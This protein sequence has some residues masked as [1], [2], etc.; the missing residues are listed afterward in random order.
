LTN[1]RDG[2]AAHAA[3]F[4]DHGQGTRF[5]VAGLVA[6]AKALDE[7]DNAETGPETRA[8]AF[9]TY[10]RLSQLLGDDPSVLSENK[11]AQVALS[12]FAQYAYE[13]GHRDES[14]EALDKLLA[15]FPK[16]RAYLQRAGRAR[17]ELRQFEAALSHWRTVLAGSRVGSDEWYEA[18]Y[19]Q[20]ACLIEVDRQA[21]AVVF[22]QL[23]VL[24]PDLGKANWREKFAA[25]RDRL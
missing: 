14:A 7:A 10:S 12:K 18:K 8:R 4:V 24:D 15:A 22:R 23:Q 9:Q 11:N 3:W 13:M 25:L 16:D 6:A 2:Q 1:D 20:I 5:E 21:A 19:H 17:F